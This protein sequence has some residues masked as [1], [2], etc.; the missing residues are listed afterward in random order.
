V[1]QH[2][3]SR[4]TTSNDTIDTAFALALLWALPAIAFVLILARL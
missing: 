1:S 4:V 2:R 3:R